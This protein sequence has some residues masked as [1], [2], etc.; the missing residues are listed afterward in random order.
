MKPTKAYVIA[1]DTP[2]SMEYA[3]HA[4]RSCKKVG[5]DCQVFPGIQDKSAEEAFE[6][7]GLEKFLRQPNMDAK[8]ACATATHFL[9]WQTI[10]N[11]NECAIIL[12]HDALMLHQPDFTIPDD[13]IVVLGYKYK[14]PWAYDH[15][16]AGP[17]THLHEIY[18]HA[19]AH[20]YAITP[21]TAQSL[22][23]EIKTLGIPQAIDNTYFMRNFPEPD[24][25]SSIRM[26]IVD[27]VCAM[28]WVRDSTIW[29]KSTTGN[30][31]FLRSFIK[32]SDVKGLDDVIV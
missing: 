16:S 11:S 22:L 13:F 12:E 17:P 29:D 15:E 8:A 9:L 23:D 27:P 14:K 2:K 1:I 10:A 4:V 18:Q 6:T 3:A 28:G 21:K 5:I 24:M 7:L 25:R 19:G 30:F 32:H 26:A 31:T 20:A